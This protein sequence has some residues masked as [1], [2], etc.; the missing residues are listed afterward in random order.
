[1]ISDPVAVKEFLEDGNLI[2]ICPRCGRKLSISEMRISTYMEKIKID[3]G[4]IS[5]KDCAGEI[6]RKEY[7][8]IVERE[9]DLEGENEALRARIYNADEKFERLKE[10]LIKPLKKKIQQLEKENEALGRHLNS[11]TQ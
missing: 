8:E 3:M 9:N 7:A 4:E 5:C 6:L 1:M 11:L 10:K 2:V